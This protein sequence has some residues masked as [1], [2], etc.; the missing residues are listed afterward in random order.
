[1][2]LWANCIQKSTVLSCSGW[3]DV[4]EGG[5]LVTLGSSSSL[6]GVF[7]PPAPHPSTCSGTCPP[8]GGVTDRPSIC[9]VGADQRHC[10]SV[11][12]HDLCR[13]GHAVFLLNYGTTLASRFPAGF[14][15]A[16]LFCFVFFLILFHVILSVTA[17]HLFFTF[18]GFCAGFRCHT[19]YSCQCLWISL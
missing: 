9:S 4:D 14:S 1:M 6:C 13:Q 8:T 10:S 5:R 18:S 16:V 11:Q 15:I 17:F 7:A 19:F 3:V 12:A 2:N